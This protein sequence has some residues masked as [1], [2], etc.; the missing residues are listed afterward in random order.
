MTS[1]LPC[2]RPSG[3]FRFSTVAVFLA[4]TIAGALF[5]F[6]YQALLRLVPFLLFHVFLLCAFAF[7]LGYVGA[8]VVKVGHCRNTMLA[9]ILAISLAAGSIS[10]SFYW[11][12][13]LGIMQLARANPRFKPADIRKEVSF[14][15]WIEMRKKSGWRFVETGRTS[16]TPAPA[17]N[18]GGGLVVAAWICESL[19]ML[20]ITLWMIH[21]AVHLPYCERCRRW[22][23]DKAILW[24]GRGR[25]AVQPFLVRGDLSG[26]IALTSDPQPRLSPNLILTGY[27]CDSCGETGF[28]TVEE[29]QVSVDKKRRKEEKKKTLLTLAVL[30]PE[31]RARFVA[32]TK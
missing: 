21:D 18:L 12:Y 10:A 16:G 20:V 11:D 32:R 29:L 30:S 13:Q 3:E 24:R 27:L 8:R 6:V 14:S 1:P 19:I 4:L 25:D 26:L 31:Q 17:A 7:A 15:Q 9:W 23:K 22:T 5:A 2:Y 28:L